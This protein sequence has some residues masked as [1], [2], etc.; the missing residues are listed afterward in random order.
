MSWNFAPAYREDVPLLISLAGPPGSGKTRTALRMASGMAGGDMS[1]VFVLD[2]ENRRALLHAHHF[3]PRFMYSEMRAPFLP[4]RFQSGIAH[5]I[6]HGALAVVIDSFSDEWEGEGGLHDWAE[7]AS[8]ASG[9]NWAAP[10]AAHKDFLNYVRQV[11]IPLIF[12]LRAEEKI[13]IVDNPEKPGKTMPVPLGW[14]PICEKRWMYDMTLS[15][16]FSPEKAGCPDGRLPHKVPDDF[17]PWFPEGEVITEEAGAQLAAW[18]ASEDKAA[19]APAA[20][21]PASEPARSK[22]DQRAD[23]IVAAFAEC[24][25]RQ[26]VMLAIDKARPSLDALMQL[27]DQ[28]PFQRADAARAAAYQL[29]VTP[30]DANA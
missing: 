3:T 26:E 13:K 22:A 5:A 7:K 9:A 2:T 6:Q 14:M 29:H 18:L 27:P 16:T 28:G 8:G 20:S 24:T 23:A 25:T 19:P 12:C 30:E 17:F 4:A 11:R 21:R 15:F 10:K 1:R